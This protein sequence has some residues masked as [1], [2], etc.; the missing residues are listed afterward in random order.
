M[1]FFEFQEHNA[2]RC[3]VQGSING[4]NYE[5]G[6]ELH[7]DNNPAQRHSD[8][9]GYGAQRNLISKV[10]QSA[11]SGGEV[12]LLKSFLS[13]YAQSKIG[14]PTGGMV[15]YLYHPVGNYLYIRARI[16]ILIDCKQN[17]SR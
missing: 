8:V 9:S 6:H 5:K 3:M 4:N 17:Q 12:L 10:L 11:N 2:L 7:R 15:C 16:F 14:S 1:R 13:A